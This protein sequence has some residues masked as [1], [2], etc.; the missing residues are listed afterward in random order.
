VPDATYRETVT[1]FYTGL[2]A[3]QTSQ[4]VLARKEFEEDDAA[5]TPGARRLGEPGAAADAAAGA[6]AGGGRTCAKAG[7]LAGADASIERLQALL[8]SR[9]GRLQEAIPHW[10]NAASTTAADLKAPYALALDLE[11]AGGDASLAERA[12]T[13]S[14]RWPARSDNL[15]VRLELARIAARRGDAAVLQ[16]AIAPLRAAAASLAGAGAGAA[17]GARS[18]AANP[19]GR[20]DRASRS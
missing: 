14:S 15:A 3:M 7:E 18:R 12:D 5:R 13:S 4:E 10:K 19:F 20:G 6:G 17:G 8:A 11:R 16:K 1:A 2:A 9:H